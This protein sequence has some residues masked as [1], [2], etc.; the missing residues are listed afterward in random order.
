MGKKKP[1]ARLAKEAARR[2]AHVAE[3][4][5]SSVSAGGFGRGGAAALRR[6]QALGRIPALDDLS[7]NYP[8]GFDVDGRVELFS[9]P[10]YLCGGRCTGRTARGQ[11]C[12]NAAWD[13]GQVAPYN[14]TIVDGRWVAFY[15]PLD[16]LCAERFRTQRCRLHVGSAAAFCDP[17]WAPFSV[18]RHVS[19]FSHAC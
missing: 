12:A 9:F 3:R 15:G 7:P 4:R 11:R 13:Q 5:Q 16:G 19:E 10:D 18:E 6:E 2:N 17:E 8:V 1:S 14:D